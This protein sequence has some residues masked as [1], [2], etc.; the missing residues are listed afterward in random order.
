LREVIRERELARVQAGLAQNQW[1]TVYAPSGSGKTTFLGQLALRSGSNYHVKYINLR[2]C[3]GLGLADM[4]RFMAREINA[5]SKSGKD[6]SLRQV[7]LNSA[8]MLLLLCDDVGALSPEV[9]GPFLNRLSALHSESRFNPALRNLRVVLTSSRDLCELGAGIYSCLNTLEEYFLPDFTRGETCW[10][11]GEHYEEVWELAEGHPWFTLFFARH[12]SEF[13]SPLSEIFREN[14]LLNSLRQ[15]LSED[16]LLHYHAGK[17]TDSR[18]GRRLKLLGLAK[19]AEGELV[20]RNPLFRS[21]IE[22]WLEPDGKMQV[23]YPEWSEAGGEVKEGLGQDLLHEPGQVRLELD[24]ASKQVFL[25]GSPIR[26]TPVEFRILEHLL[27]NCP[28]VLSRESLAQ[29][30]FPAEPVPG[31]DVESHIKNLRRKLGDKA[32]SPRFIRCRKG[33][34]YEAV[35]N[36]FRVL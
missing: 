9:A 35:K 24:S 4:C 5:E 23:V 12:G 7:L 15:R 11:V 28:R 33:F 14:S 22:D 25:E 17:F 20:V 16:L 21:V 13:N 26:L 32:A 34:G 27:V 1:F 6:R 36:S 19:E 3:A 29:A 30:A 10:L 31:T 18:Q 8:G 2:A